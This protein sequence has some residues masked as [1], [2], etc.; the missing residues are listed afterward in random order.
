MDYEVLEVHIHAAMI[1]RMLKRYG[2]RRFIGAPAPNAC[3]ASAGPI[4]GDD[5]AGA[6][7]ETPQIFLSLFQ[8]TKRNTS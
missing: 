7:L 6:A 2:D 8:V 1:L 5:V 4:H 3:A